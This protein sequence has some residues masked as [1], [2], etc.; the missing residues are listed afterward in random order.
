MLRSTNSFKVFLRSRVQNKKVAPASTCRF[1][2]L[3]Y[4]AISMATVSGVCL[5][6]PVVSMPAYAESNFGTVQVTTSSNA[7]VEGYTAGAVPLFAILNARE[8]SN[9]EP[10]VGYAESDPDHI[11][12][13]STTLPNIL[14]EV[15]SNG[16]DTTLMIEGPDQT[17][18]CSDDGND[19]DAVIRGRNWSAGQYK[20]WVGAFDSG[21]SYDYTLEIQN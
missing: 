4:A 14:I 21:Q 20:I 13:L 17:I 1:P 10:C 5:F 12:Q 6:G 3:A 8:D 16:G 18:Y 15:E 2:S 11:L 9:N 7:E 19:S